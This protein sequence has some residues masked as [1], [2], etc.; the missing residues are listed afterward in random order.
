MA[1]G[2]LADDLIRRVQPALAGCHGAA[3]L[4]ALTGKTVAQHLDHYEG[5]SS[6]GFL[7]SLNADTI[8]D[9]I[10][11]VDELLWT[12]RVHEADHLVAGLDLFPEGEWTTRVVITGN[13]AK[14][15]LAITEGDNI[16]SYD[17]FDAAIV[18]MAGPAAQARLVGDVLRADS[19]Q[20]GYYSGRGDLERV[21][22]RDLARVVKQANQLVAECWDE[23]IAHAEMTTVVDN[24]SV[25]S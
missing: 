6:E 25:S 16:A 23:I 12:T 9:A 2:E 7:C 19:G 24:V 20:I 21:R 10:A 22:V 18:T 14:P 3:L 17:A 5:L 1:L 13:N 15:L 8:D 11:L 4:P